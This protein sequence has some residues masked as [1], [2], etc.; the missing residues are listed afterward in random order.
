MRRFFRYEL[1][2]LKTRML[3][4]HGKSGRWELFI[5]W[6]TCRVSHWALLLMHKGYAPEEDDVKAV[7]SAHEI[8]RLYSEQTPQRSQVW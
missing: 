7:S 3:L 4:Q 8:V 1:D 2:G 5:E 6:A